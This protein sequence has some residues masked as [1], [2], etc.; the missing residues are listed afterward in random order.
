MALMGALQ[1]GSMKYIGSLTPWQDFTEELFD[2]AADPGE[3]N[4]LAPQRAEEVRKLAAALAE[5]RGSKRTVEEAGG[6]EDEAKRLQALG[7]LR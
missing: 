4:N 3:Q 1:S 6:D 5:R 2:L 7:Y